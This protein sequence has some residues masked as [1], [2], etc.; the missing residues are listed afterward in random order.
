MGNQK[1]NDKGNDNE[2]LTIGVQAPRAD[3]KFFSFPKTAKVSEV[4]AV[5]KA[6]SSL[7]LDPNGTYYLTTAGP[8][9]MVL[10]AERPLVSYQIHDRDVLTITA[11]GGGV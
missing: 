4:I 6:D 7:R 2:L 1:Q 5:V 8:E 10:A 11:D 3:L 9:P